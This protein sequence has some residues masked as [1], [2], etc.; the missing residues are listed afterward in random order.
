MN[1]SGPISL[2]GTTAGVSIEIENGGNGTTMISL[3]DTAVR[4]LAGVPSGAITM[5]TNFYGKSNRV[6]IAI[7]ISANTANYTLNTAKATGYVAGKSDITLTINSG[8]IVS[9]ASTGSYAFVVDTSWAAG[10]TITIVNNGTILG[11]GGNGGIGATNS[12]GAGAGTS[13]GP[14]LN[15]QR[16]TSINNVN[17]IAGGGGGGGGGAKGFAIHGKNQDD[18]GGGGGGGGIGIGSAGAGGTIGMGFGGSAGTAG[19]LTANGNGGFG[20]SSAYGAGGS[21]GTGGTYGTSGVNG[22]NAS[23]NTSTPGNGGAAGAAVVG[24]TN[25][26]WIAVGTRNGSIS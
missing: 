13:A 25:I 8:V 14:A 9:S 1:S 15:V 24:N 21:G 12:V 5:P 7:T 26:T 20:G 10:D 19:T 3:N 22:M 16:A 23:Q 6:A 18:W 2:A 11:K 17:R 4:N